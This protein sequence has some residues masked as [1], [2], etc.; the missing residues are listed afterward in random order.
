M[1]TDNFTNTPKVRTLGHPFLSLLL[2][3]VFVSAA[4]GQVATGFPPFASYSGGPDV[5]DNANGNVHINIPIFS[6]AGRGTSLSYA[7]Q[8]D[9]SV[10]TPYGAGGYYGAWGMSGGW[11]AGAFPLGRYNFNQVQEC[12]PGVKCNPDQGTG[13][14]Y[15]QYSG[16]QYIDPNGTTHNFGMIVNDSS[17]LCPYGKGSFSET[18]AT[19]DG[20]GLTMSVDA[21]P[22]AT[23]VYDI[24]GNTY[25]LQNSIIEDR[26][27][28]ET[29]WGSSIYDTLSSTTPALTISTS[30]NPATYTYNAPSGQ[31]IFKAHYQT[32][33][34]RTNFGCSGVTEYGPTS[35]GLV[36]EIDL[37]DYNATSNPN[38]KYTFTYE[39]TPGYSGDVTGR[40]TSITL[41]SGGTITYS[42]SGGYN[43][44]TCADGSIATLSRTTPDGTWTYAHSE[45]GSAWITLITDPLGNQTNMSFQ[46]IYETERQIY[47]GSVSPSH[48]LATVFTCYNGTAPPCNN[49]AVGTITQKSVYLQWPSGLEAETNI[50]YNSLGLATEE[51]DY[52]Y[53]S[54]SPGSLLRKVLT[55]YASLGNYIADKPSSIT[56]Q[57][58]SG[59]T[60]AETTYCYDE[61]TPSGSTTC[62]ATGPPTPTSGTPQHVAVT[63]SRGNATTINTL[64]SGSTFLATTTTYFDTGNPQ[65]VSDVNNAQTTYNYSNANLTCGNAFPTSVSEPLTLSKSMT[66]N[67]SGAVLTQLTDENG[68]NSSVSFTDPYYWRAASTTDQT[69]VVTNFCYGLLSSSTGVC[70]ANPSQVESTLNFNSN[71]STVDI[72]TT[73]DGLGRMHV[74]Q[75]RQSPSATSFDS[76]ESD[77]DALGRPSR[78]TLPYSAT[79]GQTNSSGPAVTTT[80][81]ALSRPSQATDA[82]GGTTTYSYSSNDVLVTVGPAPS[83][84]NTKKRQLESD[85]LGRL[86]SVCEI[87][88]GTTAWPGGTCA[89]N[90]SQTGYWT[91]Y[92]HDALGN[93]TGIT[94]NAQSSSNQQTR[95]FA[96]DAMSRL[97]SETNAE[98]GTRTY[99]YDTIS[100][101][102]CA[103]T[104]KGDLLKRVDAIGNI[105]CFTYD[106]LHRKLSASYP[107]GSYASVTPSRYFVYDSATVNS[108][109]MAN[110][111]TRLAEAYTC[112][113]CPAT[114]ITDLGLSYTARG[115]TSDVYESTPHSGGYYHATQTYWPHGA[116][117]QLSNLPGL[118]TISYGATIGSTVGLDGEGRITQVTA[119]SGQN[120]VTGVNYSSASLPTQVNLGSG[121]SDTFAYDSNTLRM[122]Q[123]KFNVGTQSQYLNGALTWN[124]NGTLG[125]L[126]ITDQFSSS[127]TQTCSYTHDDL[128]R[129]VG[130]NCGGAAS[131]TFSFDPFG[132][133]NKQGSPYTFNAFYS[134]ATNQITCIGGS[135]Q[136][137][138]GGVI[139][140]YDLN[141]N[142]TSD[143]NHTYSWD[144]DGNAISID[145]V[146]LTFDA[147]ER[148]VE[149]NRSGSYTQVLYGPGGGKLALMNAQ[150][151]VKAFAPLPGRSTAIYTSGGLDHYRHSDWLG[152]TRLTSSPSRT[153]IYS[154]A[155]APYGETYASNGAADPSFTGQN[156]D[157]VSSDNDF[158]HR[159]YSNQGR[160]PSPDPAGLAAVD[161]SNPQSWDHYAYVRNMPDALTDPLGLFNC[162]MVHQNEQWDSEPADRSG[163]SGPSLDGEVRNPEPQGG[164]CHLTPISDV[165]YSID[166]GGFYSAGDYNGFSGLLTAGSESMLQCPDSG[167]STARWTTLDGGQTYGWQYVQFVAFAWGSGG[168]YGVYG[169]GALY[170]SADEAG[171]A[172]LHFFAPLSAQSDADDSRHEYAGNLY[173]DQNGIYSY[174]GALAIG[175]D[176]PESAGTCTS[177][178][179]SNW[180]PD[181][182]QM[183]ADWHTHPWDNGS[184][185]G[186]L[187]MTVTIG[188]ISYT[189]TSW[190]GDRAGPNAYPSYVSQ[191]VGNA[192][193]IFILGT[194]APRSTC[195]LSGP[196]PQLAGFAGIGPC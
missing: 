89:Q 47:Q 159:E 82:G 60:I 29:S 145:T 108:V 155:Y 21:T 23:F 112:T 169:P 119:A 125:Q 103:G 175:P 48:L 51:D 163:G 172:A 177:G 146:G 9:T 73:V 139:P 165:V 156:P 55:S 98:S 178:P 138:T 6:R 76:I 77:Y 157:S 58:G 141:G 86:T 179:V 81:D 142:V 18:G 79:A 97:T 158:L 188:D 37:P 85:G 144:A 164:N 180:V 117:F 10:W 120:P 190:V 135:G 57:N 20:S 111:K 94:Q 136:N 114:K 68:N 161:P 7:L 27:G 168:Y 71:N 69:G 33:T 49:T 61:A 153:Y 95:T 53:G 75:K 193:A 150:T 42:Y 84:E 105:V 41:P 11:L 140:T 194:G 4:S 152:S 39:A 24:H 154:V 70:T 167:C 50:F 80:Y 187:S 134:S 128:T 17:Q 101:G 13:T 88:A 64:I 19:G 12:C 184:L 137:C 59:T 25:E 122:T 1:I 195:R 170:F 63:G 121:D 147:L 46:G 181:G 100:S 31:A 5:V 99:S 185:G 129:L 87:T 102:S 8:Y 106:A 35:Q 173:V 32:F 160:W 92:T 72:L 132:N 115:E 3:L 192:L 22:E 28:N 126:A 93:L 131:Q 113:T 30:G 45:S 127:D 110:A 130:A 162:I 189:T 74:Q 66:W 91:K 40:L 56:I 104:Y 109:A 44:I 36:T 118:P 149:Q 171:V 196:A 116:A 14:Y 182:S 54:P 43:G 78:K 143:S 186:P 166:G 96:F 183:V 176:C 2:S 15:N 107:S 65:T 83:G 52:D 38:A 62:G 124:A 133:I 34:V 151:M 16:W 174:T 90:T 67:C 191:P 123:F 148:M 26:N